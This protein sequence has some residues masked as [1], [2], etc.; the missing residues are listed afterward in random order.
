MNENDRK[1]HSEDSR[2]PL[3]GF[4]VKVSF[5]FFSSQNSTLSSP[6]FCA[7]NGCVPNCFTLSKQSVS[8]EYLF[9]LRV[10]FAG[11]IYMGIKLFLLSK[12]S[13]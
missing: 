12:D 8:H 3:K 5:P 13:L 1:A 6:A 4:L 10:N 11:F 2:I 9:Y 7:P